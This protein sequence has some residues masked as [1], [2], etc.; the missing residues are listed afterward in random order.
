[1]EVTII[2]RETIKPSNPSVL[3]HK[4]Y[5]LCLFDQ[6]IPITY[7][8]MI[9]FYPNNTPH[10]PSFNTHSLPK[11]L[12]KLKISLSEALN[13]YY[14]FAGRIKDN[15]YIDDFD[16]GVPYFEAKVN[17]RMS[18]FFK[19][20]DTEFL[21]HLVP[22]QPFRKE[23]DANTKTKSFSQCG[24]Q[25]NLFNCGGI[26]LGCSLCHK[27]ADGATFRNLLKSWTA[28]FTG[29][30]EKMIHPN[31]TGASATF[32]ARDNLAQS[33]IEL[34]E[35]IWFE[36]N[37]FITKR[38]MFDS[39]AITALRAKATSEKVPKPS[40]NEVLTAFIWKH[41]TAASTA[42]SGSP[43]LSVAA[44]AVNLRPRMKPDNMLDTCTGN[45]FWWAFVAANPTS[46]SDRELDQLVGMLKD[47]LQGFNNDF[48]E[49]MKGED[50]YSVFSDI[51]TQIEDLFSMNSEMPD[52]LGFTGWN[53][54]FN[55]IDFGWGTPFW[56]G[57][58]G[59]VG[60]AFRNL[61]IFVDSQWGK[62]IEAWIT[63]E[64]KQIAVLEND[65][66]F[67]AFASLNPGISSL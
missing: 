38:F 53:S 45:L 30:P 40:R 20:R 26:A 24:F 51:L 29:S 55:G 8:S 36:E 44:H 62:G 37:D 3:H 43:K 50:G 58:M 7:P 11:T 1:M 60:P 2:S 65:K 16:A 67:L 19:L 27:K 59:K 10:H 5:K 47:V 13:L 28:H 22:Y 39:R 54:L 64:A 52:I 42:V 57:V 18:D 23:M 34:M 49:T 63:L 12:A 35:A 25:V 14:P 4:P 41:A 6:L 31:L 61:V 9:L 46:K 32:P 17:C 33:Q 15:L 21:N 48:L 56:V 66:E